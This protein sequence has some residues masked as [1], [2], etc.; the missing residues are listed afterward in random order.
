MSL[1][2]AGGTNC[3][4]GRQSVENSEKL[5][6]L[7][8]HGSSKGTT[9]PHMS[10]LFL[11]LG[12]RCHSVWLKAHFCKWFSEP[13]LQGSISLAFS[14][15]GNIQWV[16]QHPST[17]TMWTICI[18]LR[19]SCGQPCPTC[20]HFKHKPQPVAHVLE[21]NGEFQNYG[22]IFKEERT[23]VVWVSCAPKLHPNDTQCALRTTQFNLQCRTCHRLSPHAAS[24]FLSQWLSLDFRI[25]L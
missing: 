24:S 11:A 22:L 3:A 2:Q 20:N 12:V 23:A 19:F 18:L 4:T 15:H 8:K 14:S 13:R 1:H 17:H 16:R 6:C 21:L 9:G 25:V 7:Q 5:R 10:E